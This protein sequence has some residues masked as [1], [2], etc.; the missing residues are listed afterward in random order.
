VVKLARALAHGEPTAAIEEALRALAEEGIVAARAGAESPWLRLEVG[1]RSIALEADPRPDGQ[2]R[3]VLEGILRTALERAQFF[4]D[5]TRARARFD[6]FAFASFEGLFIHSDGIV[7]EANERFAQMLGYSRAEL[8]GM[9]VLHACVAPEDIPGVIERMQAQY[10]GEY[11]V[12]AIRRDGARFRAEV[13]SREGQF[14]DR[15]VRT[16]AVRDVTQRERAAA[17]LRESEERFRNLAVAAFDF[18]IFVRD[19][20]IL[21]ASPSVES[22]LGFR[23][24]Q[25]IGRPVLEI[26]APTSVPLA[27]NLVAENRYGTFEAS[28]LD[29]SNVPVPLQCTIVDGSLEGAPVRVGGVRDLRPALKLEAERSELARQ[30]A[31]AQRLDSLGVLA[32]GIAHDFNNLLAGILGNSDLLRERLSDPTDVELAQAIVAAAQRAAD[33]TKQ[34]L[35]YAGYRDLGRRLPVDLGAVVQELR[36]LLAATLSKKAQ[37]E[38]SIAEGC[39]VSGD[40]ATL[41]QV[42]MNLLTNASDALNGERGRIDIRIKPVR[43]LDARWDEAQGATVGPGDWVL[44]EIEDTGQG[45]SPE[46]RNRVFEPF[47]STKERGHGLG[48]AACLGIVT[49]HQ[50]AILVESET[51]KGSRFSVLLPTGRARD[52][53]APSSQP[54]AVTPSYRVLIVDDEPSVRRQLRR[55]LE[56]RGFAVEEAAD[57]REGLAVIAANHPDLVIL[58]L[59]MPDLDGAEV[60]RQIRASG[61]NVPVIVSSGY[62][63]PGGGGLPADAFQAFLAKPY[64]IADLTEALRQALPPR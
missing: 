51:G 44:I 1:A 42:L 36:A 19:G 5:L 9:D 25:L 41:G 39:V 35:A 4:E 43:E 64:T 29:A 33:L 15:R 12:T 26:T 8:T 21:D 20:V 2:V 56:R 23:P 16:V 7:V 58:D 49:S 11:V 34:M 55:L 53:R 17:A 60:L 14:G 40:R 24:E 28:G 32:G 31:R 13:L 46:V 38:L 54:A 27:K 37:I 3:A 62:L 57:G 50:G 47:F 63:D 10:Q 30:L 22:V 45:M 52:Q 48:L 18:T 6:T 61:Q 59:T